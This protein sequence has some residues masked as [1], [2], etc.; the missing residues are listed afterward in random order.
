VPQ[1]LK[2]GDENMSD[3][4]DSD[5]RRA[6]DHLESAA[7]YVAQAK[8]RANSEDTDGASSNIRRAADEIDSAITIINRL[9][10]QL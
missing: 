4:L 5:L 10:R 1:A 7:E 2:I 9:R 8:R 3:N 6:K